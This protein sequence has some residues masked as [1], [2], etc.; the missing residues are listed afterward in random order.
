MDLQGRQ[1]RTACVHFT[2]AG[3]QS[4]EPHTVKAQALPSR[5]PSKLQAGAVAAARAALQTSFMPS[6]RNKAKKLTHF[7]S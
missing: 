1:E 4:P 7:C 5:V 3:S 2:K 6:K